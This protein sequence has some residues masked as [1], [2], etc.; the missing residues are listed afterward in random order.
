[1]KRLNY[2]NGPIDVIDR[3]I[4]LELAKN[5]RIT[6]AQLARMVG[7]SS[8]S[9]AERIKRLEESNIITGYRAII[10]SEALGRSVQVI[11]RIRPVPGELARVA[12]I[13]Q[14]IP[15][16]VQCDRVTGDD[17]F[18]ARA[19]LLSITDME[20]VIDLLVPYAMTNTAIVQSSPVADRL[21]PLLEAD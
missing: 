1:M 7:L 21:P 9:V 14:D 11:M 20:R 10:S 19:H 18:V 2:E 15:E 5:A 8:P 4:L 16:I 13:I 17:C 3:R 12:E 6:T